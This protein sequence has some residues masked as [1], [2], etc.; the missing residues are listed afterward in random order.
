MEYYH[1]VIGN[2]LIIM[3]NVP[4]NVHNVDAPAIVH[5]PANLET[6]PTRRNRKRIRKKTERGSGK[7]DQKGT[8]KRFGRDLEEDPE[9]MND[10]ER[11]RVFKDKKIL[12]EELVNERN[13]KDFY[14]EF[15]EYMCR[16]LQKCQKSEDGF[17]VPSG[18]QVRKPPVEPFARSAPVPRFDDPYVVARDAAAAVTTSDS[19]D[20]DDTAPIDSPY[21]M[22]RVDHLVTPVE[23]VESRLRLER[24]Q[25]EF[26]MTQ[27]S[28]GGPNVLPLR[29]NDRALTM[30]ELTDWAFF[31]DGRRDRIDMAEKKGNDDGGILNGAHGTKK[32]VRP[33]SVDLLKI[34]KGKL[35][36][37]NQNY[38]QSC[39]DGAT[40]NGTVWSR[41]EQREKLGLKTQK[42][43]TVMENFQGRL[44]IVVEKEPVRDVGGAG[45]CGC[46]EPFDSAQSERNK[47]L[48]KQLQE[49]SDIK[50]LFDVLH[51]GELQLDSVQFRVLWLA[52]DYRRRFNEGFS[53]IAKPYQLTQKNKLTNGAK[54]IE[55]FCCVLAASL[56][57]LELLFMQRSRRSSR[58]GVPVSVI[59]DRDSLFTSRF[60]VSLQKALGTQLDLSTAYH[61]ETDGQSR[62]RTI[63]TLEDMLRALVASLLEVRLRGK[64]PLTGRNLVRGN[65][66]NDCSNMYRL[67]MLEAV[68]REKSYWLKTLIRFGKS[69]GDMSTICWDHSKVNLK[70]IG[71]RGYQ[72]DKQNLHFIEETGGGL[73][74][75]RCESA[76][77]EVGSDP[78]S[79]LLESLGEGEVHMG[80]VWISFKSK[81]TYDNTGPEIR[82]LIDAEV[83]A[84]HMILNGIGNDIYSTVDACLNA[85]EMWIS[86]E[87]LQQGESINIQDVKTKLL[88]PS[89]FAIFDL[90]P[91]SLS[92]DFVFTSEIFKSL[93]FSLDRLCRLVILC[94]DQHAHTLHHL[95]SSLIIS[96]DRLDILKEDLVYQSLRKSLS[97]ILEPS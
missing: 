16:M 48:A 77:A 55:G 78:L 6:S 76:Q 5:A 34:L 31:G 20:D 91:L 89:C 27:N 25:K 18:S 60:W 32:K 96:L 92:F 75:E 86:I 13:K 15:G 47:E 69:V 64:K 42:E 29:G 79:V 93:S 11:S 85:K 4:S 14:R 53:L 67:I 7:E 23:S 22:S 80:A 38:E 21:L 90:E 26:E 66:R 62:Y 43:R 2:Y 82:K 63:Q 40:F 41:Q 50:D 49:L 24:E 94:L 3:A 8:G 37:S 73:W 19:D 58:H 33:I 65:H 46:R 30:V 1:A 74:I 88:V 72:L 45:S 10:Y 68:R 36:R 97:L 71:P 59:S 51:R 70:G 61:P 95:E 17:P 56:K 81:E 83:E 12:E 54:R 57:G 28:C 9:D 35:L 44:S 39:A 87:H 52:G 84:V